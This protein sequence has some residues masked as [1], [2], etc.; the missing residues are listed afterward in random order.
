MSFRTRKGLWSIPNILSYSRIAVI[1]GLTVLLILL[2]PR[3]SYEW[4]RNLGYAA[5]F[6]FVLTGISDLVDGYVARKY[7]TMSVMGKFIDPMADK[8]VHMA[9]MVMMIPL[10]RLPAWFVVLLLFR[11]IFI[12]GLRSVAAAEGLIMGA[13]EWG[14]KKTAT[15]HVGLS[16][17]LIYYP[18]LGVDLYSPALVCV[19]IGA[20]LAIVSGVQYFVMFL[21][22]VGRKSIG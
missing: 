11:E 17:I 9:V 14:K 20:I 7:G 13:G 2:D 3:K 8:L 15:M 12:T 22:A 4:N 21:K 10:G 5:A 19:A 6:L 16:G 1:P 18:V